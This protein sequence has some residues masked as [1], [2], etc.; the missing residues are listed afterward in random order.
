MKNRIF[1]FIVYYLFFIN[2]INSQNLEL[3]IYD[4]INHLPISFTQVNIFKKDIKQKGIYSN[5]NGFVKIKNELNK[6]EIVCNGYDSKTIYFSDIK[7]T[8][9]LNK[10]IIELDEVI[11]KPNNG[12]YYE[13]GFI[14]ENKKSTLSSVLGVEVVCFVENNSNKEQIIKSF[15]C[16][17]YKRENFTSAVRLHFYKKVKESLKPDKEITTENI[18][19]YLEGKSKKIQEIDLT[20]YF[21][22]LPEEGAFIGIEW[23]GEFDKQNNVFIDSQKYDTRIELNDSKN[24]PNTFI[25]NRLN[26]NDWG[27]LSQDLKTHTNNK[28]E[29]FLNASFGIKVF[30]D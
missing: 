5:N 4:S 1:F 29:A 12:E 6:I 20:Q 2:S 16:K 10:K 25:R 24:E 30:K 28:S 13:L 26:G 21:I 22:T 18:I 19:C 7:D 8:I 9:Y 11:V 15:L 14:K 17:I 27:N 23:L 3:V